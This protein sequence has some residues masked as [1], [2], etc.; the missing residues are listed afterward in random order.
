MRSNK[1]SLAISLYVVLLVGTLL[2]ATA[3]VLIFQPWVSC[4]GEDTSIGC[5]ADTELVSWALA[6][7]FAGLVL[8]LGSIG[9]L[10][11]TQGKR[12]MKKY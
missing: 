2:C 10:F 7:L 8:L 9:T 3:G 6:T 12:R 5:P 11:A 4:E 1:H